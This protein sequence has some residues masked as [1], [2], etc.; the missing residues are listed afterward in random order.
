[1]VWPVYFFIGFFRQG[2]RSIIK[3]SQVSLYLQL[4][5]TNIRI[6]YPVPGTWHNSST[7][8]ITVEEFCQHRKKK[9][10]W[11]LLLNNLASDCWI[12]VPATIKES[13]Q[14][15]LGNRASHGWAIVLVTVEQSCQWLLN[16]RASHCWRIMPVTVDQSCP[17]LLNNRASDCRTCLPAI[18]EH[19]YQWLLKNYASDCWRIILATYQFFV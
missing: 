7:V 5:H 12:I 3:F 11:P 17:W 14:P 4:V 1:M 19:S 6:M 9:K 15:L 18:V 2:A 10:S 8:N 13:C 16:N